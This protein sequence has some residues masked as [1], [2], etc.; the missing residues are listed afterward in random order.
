MLT[1]RARRL[2]GR[3][4]V[5]SIIRSVAEHKVFNSGFYRGAGRGTGYI[6]DA[7][8]IFA[9]TLV[10]QGNTDL[11]RIGDKITGT[12]LQIKFMSYPNVNNSPIGYA[13]L[14]MYML[15]VIIFIWKDDT[16][17][18]VGD[19]LDAKGGEF[20]V[21]PGPPVEMLNHDRK[22]KR[23]ILYDKMFMQNVDPLFIASSMSSGIHKEMSFPCSKYGRLATIHLQA[24]GV[25]GVNHLYL[26][27]KSNVP[28]TAGGELLSYN[29][30]LN[31]RYT[32]IDV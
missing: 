14:Y 3:R 19:I 25:I 2:F 26:L 5:L 31:A 21:V 8:T 20:P 27:A 22:V 10:P 23:K 15:R 6:S 29:F 17:P 1:G 32:F 30:D 24:G 4:K 13:P 28:S 7:G 9:L 18:S 16:P 11:T 12:S